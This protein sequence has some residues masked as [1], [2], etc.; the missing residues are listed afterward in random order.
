MA[1]LHRQIEAR[2]APGQNSDVRGHVTKGLNTEEF[3]RLFTRDTRDA[4]RYFSRN[5]DRA[6]LARLRWYKRPFAFLR[7][8]FLAL[9]LKMSPAR[10]ILFAAALVLALWVSLQLLRGSALRGFLSIRSSWRFPCP[11]RT[12]LRAPGMMVL[13]LLALNLLVLLEVFERLSLKNDWKSPGTS[14]RPCSHGACT[15]IAASK[16][17]DSPGPPTQWAVT[18]TTCCRCPWPPARRPR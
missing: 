16:R 14:R 12:G 1:F 8:F 7:G 17:S 9:T 15:P 4:Y 5:I 11:C 13:A 18:S 2:P 10:R 3:Q 6:E